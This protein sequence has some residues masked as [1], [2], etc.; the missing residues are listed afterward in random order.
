MQVLVLVLG[1]VVIFRAN[2]RYNCLRLKPTTLGDLEQWAKKKGLTVLFLANFHLKL[3]FSSLRA[4]CFIPRFK[5]TNISQV[6]GGNP[7]ISFL[8]ENVGV[9]ARWQ[10]EALLRIHKFNLK[11]GWRGPGEWG[12][13]NFKI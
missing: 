11:I 9:D 4:L 6:K 7:R 2:L 13:N 3:F 12:R 10:C 8:K 1:L 5:V